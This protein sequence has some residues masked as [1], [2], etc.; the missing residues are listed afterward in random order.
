M[1]GRSE[2]QK[3]SDTYEIRESKRTTPSE[4]NMDMLKNKVYNL[5][6]DE[7]DDLV[8]DISL[9]LTSDIIKTQDAMEKQNTEGAG[10]P[11][12]AKLG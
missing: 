1:K 2:N 8:K 7:Y 12:K 3:S 5:E 10:N 6:Q 4:F 9:I 11:L